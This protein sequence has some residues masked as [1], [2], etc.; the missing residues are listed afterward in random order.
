MNTR[1]KNSSK[2][3]TD[4]AKNNAGTAIAALDIADGEH[5]TE[6]INPNTSIT[7]AELI[8]IREAV[9]MCHSKNYSE[10][11]IVTD[12]RS[13]CEMLRS[14]THA[15][16]NHIVNEIS[17]MIDRDN[18]RKIYI[19]WVPS[20]VGIRWNEEVDKLAV[21]AA[22]GEVTNL[23]K[24]T[25]DDTTRLA[26]K[27]IW[28]KWRDKYKTI[29]ETKG[30][31]HFEFAKEPGKTIWC[32]NT[33]L[34]TQ[35][36][37]VLNRIRSNHCMT[38]DRKGSWGWETDTECDLCEEEE[39]LEHTLYHCLKWATIRMQYNVLETYKPLKTIFEDGKEQELKSI[40]GFL[41]EI[42][43]EI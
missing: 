27:T 31:L 30:K 9:K 41:K 22:A 15:K 6:K 38:K 4:A 35:E 39:T 5:V 28:N 13:A 17:D 1:Y 10:T 21:N 42:K 12:S 8:A 11:V 37:I 36:K 29:S 24:L 2:I 7:N 32:K 16:T 40:T 19:Q 34:T 23:E 14:E 18:N 33:T 43:I 20:H 25:L 3:Y 26:Q